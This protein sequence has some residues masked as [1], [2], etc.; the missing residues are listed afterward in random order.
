M[1]FVCMCVLS[2][3]VWVLHDVCV[4]TT[5]VLQDSVVFVCS[6]DAKPVVECSFVAEFHDH[7]TVAMDAEL[8]LFLHDLVSS[9]INEAAKGECVA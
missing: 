1:R 9:Y 5:W 8:I 2:I 6:A 4:C 3:V 7:I